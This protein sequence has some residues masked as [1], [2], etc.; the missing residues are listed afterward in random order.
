LPG[1]ALDPAWS[2]D[3]AWLAFAGHDGYAIEMF[4]VRPDGSSVTRLTS[5]GQFGRSPAWSPDGRHVAYL[6]SRTGFFEVWVV[7]I[8][9]DASGVLVAS[10]PRQLTKELHADA[11]SGVSWGR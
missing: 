3:G 5:D 10:A 11:A 4:A 9:A 8:Q 7:D 2:P 1:G 6:S